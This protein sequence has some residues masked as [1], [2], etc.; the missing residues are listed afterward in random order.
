MDSFSAK[1]ENF[2]SIHLPQNSGG[3]GHP[4]NIGIKEAKGKFIMFLD[5]D[6]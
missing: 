3:A 5:S 6:D 1:Y 4:R 2:V